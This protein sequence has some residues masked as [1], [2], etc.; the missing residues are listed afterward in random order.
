MSIL[1]ASNIAS[2]RALRQLDKNATASMATST[3]LSSGMRI[4]RAADDS[5]GLAIA[6]SL[7]SDSRIYSQAIRNV[8]D[9]L[10]MLA[11]AEGAINNLASI[12]SRISELAEQSA[13]GV[14]SSRQRSAMSAEVEALKEEY[15]RI[16]ESTSF[17]GRQIL[18]DSESTTLQVGK[19]GQSS[20][21]ISIS[22]RLS[23]STVGDGTFQAQS[24]VSSP[25]YT[26]GIIADDLNGDGNLDI[27]ANTSGGANNIL[28][29]LGNGD[30]NFQASMTFQAGASMSYYPEFKTG[31]FDG[32]GV[33]DLI[34]DAAYD[35]TIHLLIGNGNGTFE[36]QK[37]FVYKPL[38]GT[39]Y[40]FELE[41]TDFN[42]DGNLDFA[43]INHEATSSI[44]VFL[45]NG[46]GNFRAAV[47]TTTD[48]YTMDTA[49]V[50]GDGIM[51]IVATEFLT[52]NSKVLLGVGDG[53]FSI[54]PSFATSGGNRGANLADLNGDGKLD[55]VTYL[56]STKFGVAFGNGDGTFQAGV[57]YAAPNGSGFTRLNV[58][59][60]NGDGASDVVIANTQSGGSV[61]VFLN[62]GLG[63]F[64]TATS[65]ASSVLAGSPGGS[66]ALGDMNNDG[67]IDIAA[68][69]SGANYFSLF[70]GNP[71]S[72]ASIS[73]IDISTQALAR[74]AL[75]TTRTIITNISKSLGNIG[76]YQS[77]LAIAAENLSS[78][79]EN[80]LAAESR[81][82]DADIAQ[83]VAD[84]VRQSILLK[85]G[86]AVLAQSNQQPALA[87]LLLNSLN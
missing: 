55:L 62:N 14:Y 16:L 36:A 52:S 86:T 20:A 47:S 49:D 33:T 37:S 58:R 32:D 74:E 83:E 34:V 75:D 28:V 26:N 12:V 50:N 81:I 61:D 8:N 71:V 17:N 70:L 63:A 5:A 54:A 15:D 65:Y 29:R 38:G 69:G 35:N 30:G 85:A 48:A 21:Q 43:V 4:N 44:G 41:V 3:R 78:L 39:Q 11:I 51:D 68:G 84:Y 13:N 25:G 66:I 67:A 82:R 24:L 7:R 77:R 46:D 87:L 53:T 2:L 57:S 1:L 60:L 40:N 72:S 56:F 31:D 10:S 59:D 19:D 27:I 73:D 79:N 42:N 45:G 64:S 80:V 9:G 76:A 23:V 18:V 6:D 22:T